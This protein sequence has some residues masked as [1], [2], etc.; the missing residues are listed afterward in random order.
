MA[1]VIRKSTNKFTKG[2]IMDFSPENTRN[3]VLTHALNATLLTFN[4]NELS[5]QNDMGNARV[6][7]AFLPDGYIPVGTCEY[8]GIIY[9]VSYNPLEDKSQ[10]GCFPSPERNISNDELGVPDQK[11]FRTDFQDFDENGN[12]DDSGLIKSNTKYVLLKNDS[13]NPGDKFIISSNKDIYNEKLADL[14]IDK[15]KKHYA[16]LGKDPEDFELIKHPI[17]ALNIVSLEESGKIIYLNSSVRQYEVPNSYNIDGQQYKD[18]YKYHILGT[19]AE[20]NG[21]YNQKVDIDDYR[22]TL[23]SGYS[24]FKA[25][26]SGKL[27][28][29]AELIMI[30]SYSVTH[31]VQPRV[32]EYGQTVEG[33]FDIILHTE[34]SPELNENNYDLAPKLQFYY[35]ADS[36]GYLQ[37]KDEEKTLFVN[38]VDKNTG[39]PTSILDTYFYKIRLNDVY[40][41]VPEANLD[42]SSYLGDVGKFNFP[43]A[44]TYHGRLNPYDGPLSGTTDS[45]LYTK[46]TEGKYHRINKS[47]VIDNVPYYVNEVQAKFYFYDPSGLSYTEYDKDTLDNS[48]TYYKRF[49]DPIYHDAQRNEAYKNKELFKMITIPL[50]A[51]EPIVEDETIEKFQEQEIITYQEATQ[52]DI[53]EGKKLYYKVDANTY[54]SLTGDPQEGVT[55]YI[56]VVEEVMVSIGFVVSSNNASGTIY[57]FPEE[58]DYIPA[59]QDDIDKYYDFDTYPKESNPPYG[60]PI[61]LYWKEPNWGYKELTISEAIERVENGGEVYYNTQYI[62]VDDIRDYSQSNQLFIV[63]PIDTFANGMQFVPNPT[64]NYINGYTKPSGDYPKDDMLY[65]YTVSDFIPENMD[66][67]YMQEEENCYKYPDL[68]LAN[69]TIP[70]VVAQNGLDLPF[71]YSYTVVPCM[72]YGKLEHLAVS[73]TIDF[74]KLHAFNQSDFT[75][76]KYYISNDQLRLTFGADI[77]D[78]YEQTKVDGLVLEFYDCWGFAGSLEITD[79]KSYSGIFTKIISLNAY[80]ALSSKKI[81]GNSYTEDYRR[82]INIQYDPKTKTHT[83][84]GPDKTITFNSSS[85][86]TGIPK[87]ETK[88]ENDCGTLY[89]NLIYG[90]KTYL[91]RTYADG[92][93][94][95]I[96]KRD[97][98]L[99]TLPIY[100]DYYHTLTDFSIIEYP[101]LEMMLTYK[102]KDNSLMSSYVQDKVIVNG[103]NTTDNENV[104]SYLAGFYQGTS[105]DLIKYYKYTGTSEL[106]LEVGLKQEY[107]DLNLNYDPLI[108]TKFSCE[109][110]LVSDDDAKKSFTVNSGVEGLIQ[111]NQ[112][113]NYGDLIQTSVNKLHFGEDPNLI[114]YTLKEN[115]FRNTNFINVDENFAS[116]PLKINYEFVVGYTANIRDIRS[117]QVQATTICAL[118]HLQPSGEYN[119]ED[120]SIYMQQDPSGA[121]N[122]DGTPKMIYLS[123]IMFY[124]EGTSETE[125]FGLCK[126]IDITGNMTNQLTSITSVSTEAQEIRTAGKLNAG[127]PLRQLVGHLGKLTFCQPHVHGFSEVNGVNIHEGDSATKHYGIPPGDEVSWPK[128]GSR[129]DREAGFGIVPRMFLYENP[130]YNLSLNTKNAINY[131]SEFLST[132]DYKVF[133]GRAFGINTAGSDESHWTTQKMREFVGLTGTELATFNEKLLKTMS[134]IYAYNPGYD[135][136]AVNVGNITLQDYNPYFTSNLISH[137]ASLNFIKENSEFF[138]N[139]IN[140]G[141]ISITNYLINLY[142]HSV[143]ANYKISDHFESI[144]VLTLNEETG[145]VSEFNHQVDFQPNYDYCGTEVNKYLIT[146]LTYNTPVPDQLEQELEFSASDMNVIKHSDGT[147]T[148][149]KGIPNKKVLYGYNSEYDKM[150]QLDVSNYTIEADG[151][152]KLKNVGSKEVKTGSLT[153]DT[154]ISNKLFNNSHSFTFDVSEE[155]KINMYLTLNRSMIQY[156]KEGTDGTF[157]GHEFSTTSYPYTFY[158]SP[159]IR[160]FSSSSKFNYTAKVDSI[161]LEVETVLLN[162]RVNMFSGDITLYDQS[163]ETLTNLIDSNYYSDITMVNSQGQNETPQMKSYYVIGKLSMLEANGQDIGY[164]GTS[165]INV[166][167]DNNIIF[168]YHPDIGVN[169]EEHP[170][171]IVLIRVNISKVNFTVTKTSKLETDPETFIHTTKTI[172]YS[173]I[174]DSKY[175]VNSDYKNSCIKGTSITINDLLYEPSV[176][177]HRLFMRNNLCVYNPYLRGKIYYRFYN[178]GRIH[179]SWKY[180]DTKYLNNLYIFTGPCFTPETL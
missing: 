143:K 29:L 55:Y 28:I 177:G 129:D 124:N 106:F 132:L 39:K 104:K 171:V 43:K 101:E 122:D 19:M 31:S 142:D 36:Q 107:E 53:K 81:V 126:Q 23:S 91:R 2:L 70:S 33:M 141:P 149:L 65:I 111:T 134:N 90:V 156:L 89:S 27:A 169:P 179:S 175:T 133:E 41:A 34:V 13:L 15:D 10:I 14:W 18:V 117:T 109:L 56:A 130:K 50:I 58:K 154:E 147:N 46:F 100:N 74:S 24:V 47:Q 25:K 94:E 60:S 12:P 112:I 137:K 170:F 37:T 180:G 4:G 38:T 93:Q 172:G 35:L 54:A 51:T 84:G 161:D 105:L 32:D 159:Y 86:W 157:L 165:I 110:M 120:F 75:T 131:N 83:Y 3:E 20:N 5:L 153:V 80:Q 77:Y 115:E 88:D 68:K 158:M 26:T 152:L 155:E 127:E 162:S 138:N 9:I 52:Q 108:N 151:T 40:T 76:W 66:S 11:L 72:N 167:K 82:N 8:G 73:N 7:T 59:K 118:Y 48:Y 1:D 98:F 150:I 22:N 114:T 78:T 140:I 69:I 144:E 21:Q 128:Y 145:L 57:Y 168:K 173:G 17:I 160:V 49:E 95:F 123:N 67:E 139:Y 92:T 148:Y 30:D 64:Y 166:D 135:S 121:L 16:G 136:L 62:V 103:F 176:D 63:V 79:K 87:D 85:G 71:K 125:V 99:F 174:I 164:Y 97:F 44:Y 102:L 119:C 96:K 146:S 178:D 42:L 61:T 163:Y 6:E 45:A 116:V 113:L